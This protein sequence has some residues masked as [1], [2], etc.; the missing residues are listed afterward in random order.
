MKF[1]KRYPGD[2]FKKTMGL[3]MA[4]RGAY[5]SLL[6]WCYANESDIDFEEVY[7]ICGAMT[8][9]DR[10]DV[11]KVLSRYF[12]RTESGWSHDRVQEELAD[13][14]PRLTAARKNGKLGGRP[15][16]KKANEN[17]LGS[18]NETQLEPRAKANQE[19]ESSSLR[20]EPP[21]PQTLGS[22]S[23]AGGGSLASPA[24]TP[25]PPA[26]PLQP[27]PQGLVCRALKAAG[28]PGVNPGHP[29]LLALVEA[30]A[31]VE[32]FTGFVEAAQKAGAG[33]S[34]IVSAV[35]NERTRAAEMA[36]GLHKG[37]L[38][39]AAPWHSTRKGIEDMG[40]RLGLGRWD[41]R[42]FELG[43]GELFQAYERRVR[44]AAQEQGAEA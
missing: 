26:E 31:T 19:P 43:R 14:L 8:D 32:E 24:T 12:K 30:G 29:K 42:A 44:K 39:S 7:Q 20:S 21:S 11:D 38:Q 15:R 2:F 10:R 18:E 34:W 33:F 41:S 35:A 1:Y 16:R 17:P 5:N 22:A 3:S 37:S 13:A 40:E 4:Q 28:V 25:N 6:D 36:K 23:V 9:Q 27:T